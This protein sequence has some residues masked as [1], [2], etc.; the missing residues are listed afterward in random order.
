MLLGGDRQDAL[1]KDG[2]QALQMLG[3]VGAILVVAV[4]VRV[5]DVVQRNVHGGGEGEQLIFGDGQVG[6]LHVAYRLIEVL[7]KVESIIPDLHKVL[8]VAGIDHEL[9]II[10]IFAR[11]FNRGEEHDLPRLAALDSN[12][13]P[14]VRSRST[15]DLDQLAF[16]GHASVALPVEGR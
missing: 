6:D 5:V 13:T 3:G 11:V 16:F 7:R 12:P 4:G 15:A 10:T 9:T 8:I 1:A 14:A 2:L